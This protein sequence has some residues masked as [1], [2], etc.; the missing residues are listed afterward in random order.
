MGPPPSLC[1]SRSAVGPSA[2]AAARAAAMKAAACTGRAMK[3]VCE[4]ST[5]STVA[6]IR[7]AMNRSAA[8]EIALSPLATWYQVR[9]SRQPAAV[10]FSVYAAA[11]TRT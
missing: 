2:H 8:G 4:P 10:A 9:C 11:A 1:C 6:F 3:A 5:S 7:S